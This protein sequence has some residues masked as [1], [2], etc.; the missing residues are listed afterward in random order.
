[1]SVTIRQIA[2]HV[3]MSLP[4][5]SH[6]L[7][8]RGKFTELT[9]TRVMAAARELGYVPNGAARAMRNQRTR[10]IG[11]VYLNVEG[12]V[13]ASH[14]NT[15]LIDGVNDG[16]HSKGY[17]LCIV[18]AS[19]MTDD[20]SSTPHSRVFSERLLDGVVVLN[21]VTPSVENRIEKMACA[22]VWADANHWL[23]DSCIRRNEFRA[24]ELGARALLEGGA[25]RLVYLDACDVPYEEGNHY[26][27]AQRR[28]GV[29]SVAEAAG[30]EC[31]VVPTEPF[32]TDETLVSLRPFL[33]ADRPEDRFGILTYDGV[34]RAPLVFQAAMWLGRRPGVDFSLAACDDTPAVAEA[35]P[36]L[37]RVEFNRFE[38]GRRAAQ[39]MLSKL[40]PSGPPCPSELHQDRLVL[41]STSRLLAVS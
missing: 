32:W 17:V 13:S 1:M 12:R 34:Y 40:D 24:G 30:V 2:D 36:M 7:N 35:F 23:S 10:Q 5:V 29:M 18:R 15:F 31:V 28:A 33:S 22:V 3:G 20:T 37:T 6:V 8:H 14:H 19:D 41:G 4:T 39:M 11:I 25:R 16:L 9:R 26:S 27:F 38:L 21:V